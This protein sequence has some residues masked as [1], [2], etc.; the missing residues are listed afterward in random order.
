[1]Q[2]PSQLFSPAQWSQLDSLLSSL[3]SGQRLWLS[4]YLAG[5]SLDAL[6]A[7]ADPQDS[8]QKVLITFGTETDNCRQLAASLAERCASAGIAAE[9]ADLAKIRLRRFN[10]LEHLVVITAT[11]GDGDPPEPIIP[12][13]EAIMADSATRFEGLKFAVL[14]L[15]DSSYEHFCVTGIQFDQRLEELG[16]ERLIPRQD[17]DVDFARPANQ[18][19]EQLLAKLPRTTTTTAATPVD[20]GAASANR[21]SKEQPLTVEVLSNLNLSHEQRPQP[22][23]HL[24]LALDT[25]DFT[26]E[27]GDAVG[28]LAENPP[29]LV[30]ML[31]DATGLSGEQPVTL[32]QQAMSLVEALRRRCDLTIPGKA[33][34]ELWAQLTNDPTLDGMINGDSKLLRQFL[35]QHQIRDLASRFPARPQAQALVDALRPLQPRL[36]D[37][38]NSLCTVADELHL[39]V[40]AYD[41]SFGKRHEAGIASHFLL[42]LQPGDSLQIYPHRNARFHLPE[43]PGTPLILIGEGTGIAPYRAFWQALAQAPQSTPCWLVFAEHSFE[44]DFLYQLDVQQAHQDGVLS[45]VDCLFFDEQPGATLATP[46]LNQGTRLN[47][48][49]LQGAHLYLCGDKAMLDL[50]ENSLA[51]YIDAQQGQGQWKQ[52]A[53]DKRIHRNLY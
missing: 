49:L 17:C 1:M 8:G 28:I 13:Y 26:I 33:F 4:G 20:S 32:D 51:E 9:V 6:L 50:C 34:L 11:H 35:R 12:F 30:A 45:H 48:W 42:G 25:D 14:A 52:L 37:V 5:S 40:K 24:D 21:Y 15:G 39:A 41:Y 27:P 2:A 46:L 7:A 18:W 23:H 38:A 29:E 43:Q 53:K 31:L 10:K 47:E 19:M 36:Y 22:I 44:E 3:D 16:G